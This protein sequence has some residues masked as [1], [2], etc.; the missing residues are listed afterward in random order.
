MAMQPIEK[1]LTSATEV[2]IWLSLTHTHTL[3]T[4]HVDIVGRNI[5]VADGVVA[6]VVLVSP[7]EL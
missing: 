6:F 1:K 4:L 7:G 5:V 3:S 2:N